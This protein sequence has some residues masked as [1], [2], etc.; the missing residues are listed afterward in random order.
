MGKSHLVL[1]LFCS[2]TLNINS[3]FA[4]RCYGCIDGPFTPANFPNIGL[5]TYTVKEPPKC[6]YGLG[7]EFDCLGSCVKVS[8][9]GIFTDSSE[10]FNPYKSTKTYFIICFYVTTL[11]CYLQFSTTVL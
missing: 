4:L 11:L 5:V 8:M 9:H 1:L 6:S 2:L 10:F 7:K 3:G